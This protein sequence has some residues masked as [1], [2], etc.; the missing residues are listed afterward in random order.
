MPVRVRQLLKDLKKI[1]SEYGWDGQDIVFW[2]TSPKTW[3]A[4]H[5]RP[6]G[7]LHEPAEVIA[8]LTDAAG[9]QW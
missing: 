7:H 6:V 8:A 2:M 4:D 9:G 1:S 5:G 3:F